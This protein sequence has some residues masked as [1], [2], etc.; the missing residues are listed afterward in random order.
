MNEGYI[1]LA[2]LTEGLLL[3]DVDPDTNL[4]E[5]LSILDHLV[6]LAIPLADAV[7][8]LDLL[9]ELLLRDLV[10]T[11]V[12]V[13]HCLRD[14]LIEFGVVLQGEEYI[15]LFVYVNGVLVHSGE[16]IVDQAELNEFGELKAVIGVE[17]LLVLEDELLD[18]DLFVE[19]EVQLD[20]SVDSDIG[21]G[22]LDGTETGGLETLRLDEGVDARGDGVDVV[23]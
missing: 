18:V 22:L 6:N 21:V 16:E 12:V 15:L 10:V 17:V 8:L 23:E 9:V 13:G 20:E 5:T 2:Y 1:Q 19:L 3:G 4:I 11:L 14:G 7:F